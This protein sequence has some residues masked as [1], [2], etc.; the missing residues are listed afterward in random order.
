MGAGFHGDKVYFC[1]DSNGTLQFVIKW[2]FS[3]RH[4]LHEISSMELLHNLDLMQSEIVSPIALGRATNF[5]KN[6]Y[7]IVESPGKGATIKSLIDRISYQQDGDKRKEALELVEKAVSAQGRVIGELHSYSNTDEN[8]KSDYMEW[9]IEAIAARLKSRNDELLSIDDLVQPI[10]NLIMA[11]QEMPHAYRYNHGD[12]NL[13]NF[14]Y[15]DETDKLTLIDVNFMNYSIGQDGRPK[16]KNVDDYG[17][18]MMHFFYLNHLT[19][20]EYQLIINSFDNAYKDEIG[21]RGP[22]DLELEY[23]FLNEL[24]RDI[25]HKSS[26][27]QD[28]NQ[29]LYLQI[30]KLRNLINESVNADL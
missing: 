26:L 6:Y 3:P 21:N 23:A 15:D 24:M 18:I 4:F 25:D 14:L 20:D 28:Q 16:Y 1:K 12:P 10:K 29:N 17:I 27:G 5:D 7:L 9:N 30:Q 22:T 2:F 19:P 13:G 8:F 11:Y